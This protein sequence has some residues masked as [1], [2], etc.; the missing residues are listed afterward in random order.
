MTLRRWHVTFVQSFFE[1]RNCRRKEGSNPRRSPTG[2]HLPHRQYRKYIVE[3]KTKSLSC[4]EFH[5][6]RIYFLTQWL[7]LKTATVRF[8]PRLFVNLWNICLKAL[9]LFFH[10][11]VIFWSM[12]YSLNLFQKRTWGPCNIYDWVLC[13]SNSRQLKPVNSQTSLC[14]LYKTI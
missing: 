1:L 3:N 5:I 9:W 6:L 14:V 10:G 11:F 7:P 8:S 13:N 4:N 2:A 12:T